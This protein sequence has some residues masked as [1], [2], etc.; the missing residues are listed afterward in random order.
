MYLTVC[1]PRLEPQQHARDHSNNINNYNASLIK[2]FSKLKIERLVNLEIQLGCPLDAYEI[3]KVV[4]E[5]LGKNLQKLQFKCDWSDKYP[6]VR[7]SPDVDQIKTILVRCLN[8]KILVI[9]GRH[10]PD[11]FLCE[12][13]CM[14]NLK[15][16]VD[17]NRRK[18]MKRFKIVNP[19]FYETMMYF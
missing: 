5:R 3:L 10:L 15:L 7:V 8:L 9:S 17:F 16:V 1:T 18:S 2:L 4:I 6:E 13:E 14:F 19:R 11:R 12:I